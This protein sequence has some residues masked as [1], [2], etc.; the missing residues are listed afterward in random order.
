MTHGAWN[1][2]QVYLLRRIPPSIGRLMGGQTSDRDNELQF[3]RKEN[4]RLKTLLDHH[5]IPWRIAEPDFAQSP[6]SAYSSVDKLSTDEKVALFRRLFRG[7]DDVYARRWESKKGKSGYSPVCENEWKPNLCEKPK[8]KCGD[9]SHRKLLPLT[10]EVIYGHLSGKHTIGV[11]PLL[12]DDLCRFLTVDF[13]KKQWREDVQAFMESC[14]EL[15]V[16]AAMEISRSGNGAHV[17]FFFESPVSARDARRLGSA[18]ISRTCNRSRQLSLDSYDRLFPN[19]DVMPQ[20]GFGNLIALPLQK[21]PREMDRSVFIDE[22]FKPYPDQWAFLTSLRPLS[23]I[24]LDKAI[25]EASEGH[26][27]LD[28]PIITTEDEDAPWITPQA[29]QDIIP[30]IMPESLKLVLANLIFIEKSLLPQALSNR[31]FRLAAFANPEFYKAQAM[32]FPVWDKPRII[33]CAEN[34]PRHIGLPRGCLD[35]VTSLLERQ[36][37]RI[38]IQDERS[39]GTSLSASFNGTLRKDQKKAVREMLKEDTGVLSAPTALGKTV[40]AAA[41]IAERKVNTL[42][43]VHR[44]ELLRQWQERLVNFLNLTYGPPG[45]YGEARR[46]SKS[47]WT[48]RLCSR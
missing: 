40:V 34:F 7:R 10:D 29:A 31:L 17:W 1:R 22:N 25:F 44:T 48:S 26:H 33:G 45:L 43:L 42:I 41:L 8:I 27:P 2:R 23:Q 46:N 11:Y 13:D 28:I 36:S 3:L 39:Q 30:G 18:L 20:G 4:K 5:K 35:E 12:P 37:I 6:S 14:R 16:P 21:I 38:E 9:C 32:R 19:Q 47:I 15:E 24:D